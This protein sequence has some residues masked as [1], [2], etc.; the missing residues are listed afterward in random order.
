MLDALKQSLGWDE[1]TPSPCTV[2]TSV[3]GLGGAKLLRR[4]WKK[5][6]GGAFAEHP[7]VAGHASY[8]LSSC[9]LEPQ[10]VVVRPEL[11]QGFTESHVL[12]LKKQAALSG[13]GRG[14][15]GH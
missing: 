13:G 1:S 12:S 15:S 10:S 9:F 7:C 4:R 8:R 6:Q 14:S 3:R 2:R 11:S 5:A